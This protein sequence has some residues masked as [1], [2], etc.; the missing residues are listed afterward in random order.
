MKAGLQAE[1]DNFASLVFTPE[2][3]ALIHLFFAKNAS[4]KNPYKDAAKPVEKVGV[5]GAGLM[6]SGIAQV[7]AEGEHEVLLKDMNFEMAAKGKGAIWKDL[8]KRVGRGRSP[9]SVTSS[10]SAS[11]R[12]KLTTPL[13]AWTW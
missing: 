8:S 2:S 11:R 4:E 5:L 9:S 10:R 6:G 1:A 3:R 13:T 12:L 7:S